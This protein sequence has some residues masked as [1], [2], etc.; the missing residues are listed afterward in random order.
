M[1]SDGRSRPTRDDGYVRDNV[2]R[3]KK[4]DHQLHE[5][6]RR[7]AFKGIVQ[8]SP[9]LQRAADAATYSASRY[10]CPNA[11]G[12]VEFRIKPNTPCKKRWSARQARSKIQLS[13]LNG[14]CSDA[15]TKDGFP[16]RVWHHDLEEDQWY[17]A[18]TEDRQAGEYHGYPVRERTIPQELR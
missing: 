17:E 2:P 1:P 9:K 16:R 18:R 15:F 12:Q 6:R 14:V 13:I 5:G 11:V 4:R 8:G 7:G 3:P 10:H